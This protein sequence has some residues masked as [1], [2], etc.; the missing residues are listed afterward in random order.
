MPEAMLPAVV[1]VVCSERGRS[2]R[3]S[4]RDE[5]DAVYA[6]ATA[7]DAARRE[8]LSSALHTST[9]RADDTMSGPQTLAYQATARSIV[10]PASRERGRSDRGLRG[11]Q[12]TS[13]RRS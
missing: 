1:L 2:A 10:E 6:L 4:A 12:V 13:S 8:M 9:I 7:R 11:W 5:H 3:A